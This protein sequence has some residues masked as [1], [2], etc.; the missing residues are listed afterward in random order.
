MTCSLNLQNED[1]SDMV[2]VSKSAMVR[3]IIRSAGDIV[4]MVVA[5]DQ[6]TAQDALELIDVRY[7]A[8]DAVADVYAAMAD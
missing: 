1:G 8:V 3:D 7:D 4:A 6:Q 5:E 2:K